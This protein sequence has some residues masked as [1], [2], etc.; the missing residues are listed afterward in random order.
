MENANVH[1]LTRQMH[2]H[3]D[4]EI[5]HFGGTSGKATSQCTIVQVSNPA[6]GTSQE[7]KQSTPAYLHRVDDAFGTNA[8]TERRKC[9]RAVFKASRAADYHHRF[10]VP[11]KGVLSMQVRLL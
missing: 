4:M 7:V 11:A 5:Y 3:G 1:R 6:S 8:E 10:C 9:L 2:K